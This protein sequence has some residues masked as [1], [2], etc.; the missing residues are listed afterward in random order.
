LIPQFTTRPELAGTF[1]MVASTHWLASA[2][3]MAV[4]EK[5]GNAFDAAAAAGFVLQV[6]EPHLNGP[7]GEVPVI[8]HDARRGET[9]VVCGQGPAPAA[10]TV[11]AYA[12][13]D[14]VPGSGLLAACVPGAFGG[15]LL[16]LREYGTLR[17][18][19]VLGYAIGYAQA[20]YPLVPAISWSIA[21]VADLFREHW[22]SSAEVYLA[23][24][25]V[26]APGTLFANPALAATY[27]R[28]LAEAEAAS[29]DRD[30]QLEAA[31][32]AWYDGFVAEE[33]GKF[34]AT[35]VMDVT[36]QRHRGL[37]TDHD[38]S[39]WH[40]R[41]E[42][43]VSYEYAGLE[44]CKTAPWGQG[45]VFLQQLALLSGFDLAAMDP[46]SADYIHTLTEVTKLAFADREAWYGD[47][48]FSDVPLGELLSAAYNDERRALIGETANR[49]LRPGRPGGREMELP[50]FAN[51]P[52]STSEFDSAGPPR[53]SGDPGI[54]PATGEPLGRSSAAQPQARRGDTCHLDV[55]DRWGNVV[56]ATPSGGWLQSSPVIPALGFALGTRA[57]MFTLTPGLPATIAPGKRPRTTLTP[58]LALR[59][60]EPYLAFGTPGGDQQDQWTLHFFLDHVV[61]GMNLQQ[62][63]D[64]PAFHSAHMPSSFY[65]RESYPLRLDIEERAGESVIDRLRRR[66][67]DV[68]VQ[69]PWSLGRISAVA[70]RNGLLYAAANPR[71]MQ[72]Y[73]VGR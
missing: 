68:R 44:V 28:V 14:L 26:P 72:G 33:I 23:S 19:D 64:F 24:G 12:G 6:V 32:R 31:R 2:A 5:G 54:D 25:G 55:A 53:G 3:G 40:A 42:P 57:Q 27:K 41:L 10:A 73:A 67:H 35:E 56:T 16:L 58:T 37:L 15:W 47:P 66:G 18:R 8:G 13:F 7:G 62:A 65:P 38:L 36:G 63:I 29:A 34:A 9:F 4:L 39:T 60:G 48:A 20:G 50:D 49:Q 1:G 69:P 30:E 59:A 11:E 70:R 51:G 61:F 43:P 17:L 22:H 45:P 71:G 52:F 21:S 46:G